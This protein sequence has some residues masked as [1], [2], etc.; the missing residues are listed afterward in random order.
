MQVL[1]STTVRVRA[2][3]T[4]IHTNGL[5]RE[6]DS[7]S[8][9]K[10][11]SP[12]RSR[13]TDSPNLSHNQS[14]GATSAR[15]HPE[16]SQQPAQLMHHAQIHNSGSPPLLPHPASMQMPPMQTAQQPALQSYSQA[17]PAQ[18]ISQ[19]QMAH[20]PL[21]MAHPPQQIVPSTAEIQQ[22]L[23]THMPQHCNG[24]YASTPPGYMPGIP[25]NVMQQQP[26]LVPLPKHPSSASRT[27]QNYAPP[28]SPPSGRTSP[29]L[30]RGYE[31][32]HHGNAHAAAAAAYLSQQQAEEKRMRMS[33]H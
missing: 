1:V 23:M 27:N 24:M 2:S 16:V 14:R 13:Q 7:T 15:S 25:P 3:K 33:Q 18:P 26:V 4:A 5:Q 9:S 28:R 30:K 10:S 31:D 22:H 21:Q 20:P 17:Q 12:T 32:T 6:Q 8:G 11:P 29:S 19:A